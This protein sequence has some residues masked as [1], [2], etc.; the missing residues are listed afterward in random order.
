MEDESLV[1]NNAVRVTA[2]GDS[3]QMFVGKVVS[4]RDVGTELLQSG[5]AFG[6]RSV[7]VDKAADGREISGLEF[8]D[9]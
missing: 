7:R 2:I 4:Q 9:R 1:D 5:F 8:G 3:P 6:A